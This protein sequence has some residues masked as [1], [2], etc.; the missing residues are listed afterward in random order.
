MLRNPDC[1]VGLYGEASPPEGSRCGISHA[2]PRP[3]ATAPYRLRGLVHGASPPQDRHGVRRGPTSATLWPHN[4]RGSR[5]RFK[6]GRA[7]R[8][9]VH[10]CV[11]H[12]S[13][14]ITSGPK[15]PSVIRA[16]HGTSRGNLGHLNS[17][18]GHGKPYSGSGLLA[19]A[20]RPANGLRR[21]GTG[22][23]HRFGF[24]LGQRGSPKLPAS[25]F[26]GHAP[27]FLRMQQPYFCDCTVSL[28]SSS[29]RVVA[30]PAESAATCYFRWSEGLRGQGRGRTADL[31]LF[32][33][34]LVPT[35]L[36]DR[37]R[38]SRHRGPDGI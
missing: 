32:R 33:R 7:I 14:R 20:R 11:T 34:T 18:S 28:C 37:G 36:P 13:S 15:H 17:P 4:L 6:V 38:V 23:D 3:G 12:S 27:R 26:N 1:R 10:D 9:S 19:A 29:V 30:R 25:A 22:A 35:E 16:N 2:I 31:P 8:P 21:I 24:T 5:G